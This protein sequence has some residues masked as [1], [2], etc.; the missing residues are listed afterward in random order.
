MG[1]VARQHPSAGQ[2]AALALSG[3][4]RSSLR[5]QTPSTYKLVL[6]LMQ[7]RRRSGDCQ[8]LIG[9]WQ[10]MHAKPKY[11]APAIDAGTRPIR[12]ERL[13]VEVKRSGPRCT[14]Q[15]LM[16]PHEP[17]RLPEWRRKPCPTSHP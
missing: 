12:V 7:P 11:R 1:S 3:S 2:Q 9:M 5:I 17:P 16:R 6:P 15:L 10:R 4:V 13:S 8:G 14:R